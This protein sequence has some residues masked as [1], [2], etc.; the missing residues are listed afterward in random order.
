MFV[1]LHLHSPYSFLDGGRALEDLVRTA[2]HFGMPSLALTDHNS[3]AA[4]VKFVSLCEGY[5][6]LPI[7]GVELTMEDDTHL[8]LLA[9]DRAG[10][11]NLC[12]LISHAYTGGGR[13]SPR[14]PWSAVADLAAGVIC[15]S[16]CRKGKVPSLIRAH[17]Y[18][19]AKEA[20]LLLKGW[21]R[22]HLY[23]ELQEDFDPDSHRICTDLVSLGRELN[24]P[25]VA[26][27][28]VH[29]AKKSDFITHDI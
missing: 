20:A 12:T 28:N 27:N 1:H 16:G 10:Y 9:R 15:L 3:T 8:T 23:L 5:G 4:A 22:E 18:R 14:V 2:A 6:I 13:L 25:V 7:L 21:F 24:I 17:R 11:G 29:Y 26:T 19:E